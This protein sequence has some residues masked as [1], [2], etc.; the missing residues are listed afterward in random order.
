M[1]SKS[2]Y[3]WSDLYAGG[4]TEERLMANKQM[5]TVVLSRNIIRRGEKVTQS[6]LKLND[7]E[8]DALIAGGSIRPYPVPD[9]ASEYLSPAA[10]AVQRISK[11]GDI[12]TNVLLE[13]ALQNPPAMNPPADEAAELPEGT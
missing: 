12:D 5:R 2:Y 7:D 10:A 1:A 4:E 3:A 9:E 11:G 6:G 13:L 8:W